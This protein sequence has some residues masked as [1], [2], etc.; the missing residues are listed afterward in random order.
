MKTPTIK[1]IRTLILLL[2]ISALPLSMCKAQTVFEDFTNGDVSSNAIVGSTPIV[3]GAWAG[4]DGGQL[5]DYGYSSGNGNEAT[6]YSM[7]TDG[8][9][10]SV[11]GQFTSTLGTGQELIVS[12]DLLGF[13]GNWPHS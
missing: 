10:R 11:F 13:G 7:Y 12:F 9:G 1:V 2:G 6:P 8:A 3:G 5:F 4:S